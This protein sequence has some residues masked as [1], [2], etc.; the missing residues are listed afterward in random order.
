MSVR[1]GRSSISRDHRMQSRTEYQETCSGKDLL[2]RMTTHSPSFRD[3]STEPALSRWH[4]TWT[5]I[6]NNQVKSQNDL[7]SAVCPMFPLL[8]GPQNSLRM[9]VTRF[10]M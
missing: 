7:R 3:M 8:H 10:W 5:G 6:C 4:G 9:V 2:Y 1:A